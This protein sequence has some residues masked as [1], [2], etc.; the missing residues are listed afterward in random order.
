MHTA[1]P[2]LKAQRISAPARTLPAG[3]RVKPAPLHLARGSPYSSPLTS[4]RPLAKERQQDEHASAPQLGASPTSYVQQYEQPTATLS[5]ASLPSS[6]SAYECEQAE[7]ALE[8]LLA[9]PDLDLRV[10]PH[11]PMFDAQAAAQAVQLE[12]ACAVAMLCAYGPHHAALGLPLLPS[13]RGAAP[14]AVDPAAGTG[15]SQ[16]AGTGKEGGPYTGLSAAD[17]AHQFVHRTLY[18]LN[19][20]NLFWYDALDNYANERSL[21]LARLRNGLEAAWQSWEGQQLGHDTIDKMRQMS[22]DEIKEGLRQRYTEDV[23]PP[24]S[25]VGSYIA[26]DMGVEGYR[27]LLAI[28][29]L[30]GLVEASRQSRVCGGAPNDVMCMIFKVLMEEYGAGRMAKK[31]STFFA[32]MMRELKLDDTP[33]VYLDEVP[34]QVLA[35]A[36]H[37]FLLTERRRHYLRYAAG[38]SFFEIVG[39]S[40]YRT[41]LAAAQRLNLSEEAAGY[42]ALHIKEDERHG[43]W[44]LEDV[45]VP[46]VDKYPKD[47][48]EL[49]LGYDQEKFMATRAAAVVLERIR[50]AD[51]QGFIA[52]P[53][54][55]VNSPPPSEVAAKPALI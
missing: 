9:T 45:A 42:W 44:M 50:K 46:L 49:L 34:W 48:W 41:Y 1:S 23:D 13:S 52:K 29:S 7:A 27:Q 47:S 31:H 37:N 4:G 38:L 54:P 12:R 36:N 21:H 19:R 40:V 30:D 33:E 6:L 14:D 55:F 10:A 32:S 43:R 2:M 16:E 26:T 28:A 25:A 18:R 51:E 11:S 15:H 8:A 24:L 20:L 3:L 35:G 5:T 17:A 22:P 53:K 39:P